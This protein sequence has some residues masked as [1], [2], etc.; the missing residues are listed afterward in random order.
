VAWEY[1]DTAGAV[2]LTVEQVQRAEP[3]E[4]PLEIALAIGDTEDLA[5][6]DVSKRKETFTVDVPAAVS[7]VTI[8]PHTWFFGEWEIRSDMP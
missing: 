1:D 4:F 3:F 6:L 8:D 2:T 7:S 5:V